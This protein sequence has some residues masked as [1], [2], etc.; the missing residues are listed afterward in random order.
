MFKNLALLIWIVGATLLLTG[1][2]KPP[3][4]PESITVVDNE[5]PVKAAERFINEREPF[6]IDVANAYNLYASQVVSKTMVETSVFDKSY[7]ITAPKVSRELRN[8]YKTPLGAYITEQD[9]LYLKRLNKESRDRVKAIIDAEKATLRNQNKDSGDYLSRST[10]QTAFIGTAPAKTHIASLEQDWFNQT[11]LLIKKN[12]QN[13][14]HPKLW[15]LY[16]SLDEAQLNQ[17]YSENPGAKLVLSE[18]IYDTIQQSLEPFKL[19][20]DTKAMSVK[21]L[22]QSFKVGIHGYV[23]IHLKRLG[24]NSYLTDDF[25]IRT[26]FKAQKGI[27][28]ANK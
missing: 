7:I 14:K 25:L 13:T 5:A 10:V 28:R 15:E 16:A 21:I 11:A 19:E 2:Q 17:Y 8:F 12:L 1:C 9:K 26:D 20:K 22:V 6:Y 18:S 27:E 3:T 23:L 4:F 24:V